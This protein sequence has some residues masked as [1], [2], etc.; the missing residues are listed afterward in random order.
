MIAISTRSVHPA[1]LFMRILACFGLALFVSAATV[2]AKKSKKPKV[3]KT[4]ADHAEIEGVVRSAAD[5]TV[6]D[7]VA[8]RL[9]TTDGM[10]E[11]V[12]AEDGTFSLTIPKAAG[13]YTIKLSRDGYAA[14]EVEVPLE[15]GQRYAYN[16]ALVDEEVGRRQTAT[17]AYNKGAE[18]YQAGDVA[19]AKVQFELAAE[20]NPDLIEAQLGL[21]NVFL[22]EGDLEAART[23]VEAFRAA[24][25]DEPK[26]QRLAF[27]VYMRQGDIPTMTTMIDAFRETAEAPN[28]AAQIYNDGVAVMREQDNQR[29]IAFFDLA[30]ALDPTLPEPLT[31]K[32]TLLY[33]TEDFAGLEAT[34]ATLEEVAPN[35]P[36]GH[37]LRFLLHD[38][39]EETDA[40]LAAFEAYHAVDADAAVDLLYKRA[41]LDFRESRAATARASL[42]RILTLQPDH[43]RAH[44]TLGLAL[45]SAGDNAGARKHL[46]RFIELTPDD[47]EAG[48]AREMLPHLG[49]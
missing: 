4:S 5:E 42:E 23:A 35:H 22:S 29:A 41:E 17:K 31:G 27:E 46:G 19:G 36:R 6:L 7:N 47:P 32:A 15:A 21:A 30:H 34:L 18:L 14:Y 33:N 26:S 44:Y 11:A 10:I 20:A 3:S 39:R 25:P 2:D 28:L 9:E 38:A 1:R 48:A 43:A 13:T 12:S 16:F 45:A 40:A 37:R 8:I 24:K 49:G